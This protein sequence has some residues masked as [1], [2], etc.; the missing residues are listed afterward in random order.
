MKLPQLSL[1]ELFLLVALAAMGCGWWVD[2]R[3]AARLHK[4]VFDAIADGGFR[5]VR[6]GDK[7]SDL[8]L[9]YDSQ[10]GFAPRAVLDF[11]TP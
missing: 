8:Q 10:S 5:L 7:S 3:N 2:R 4:A 1:R 11:E 9:I 6:K